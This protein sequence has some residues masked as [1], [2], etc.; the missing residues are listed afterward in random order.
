MDEHPE[1]QEAQA[2][3]AAYRITRGG[4]RRYSQTFK[5]QAV[6]YLNQTGRPISA[7][8]LELG[9]PAVTLWKWHESLLGKKKGAGG[10]AGTEGLVYRIQQLQSQCERLER[11]RQQLRWENELLKKVLGVSCPPP[12]RGTP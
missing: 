10:E 8:A 11:E 7:V 3:S 12:A 1:E 6:E 4:K 2:D 5:A 9:I